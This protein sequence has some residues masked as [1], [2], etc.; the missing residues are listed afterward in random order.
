[1]M[2]K[3][4]IKVDHSTVHHLAIK[5]PPILEKAL[6]RRKRPSGGEKLACRNERRRQRPD[7]LRAVLLADQI[8]IPY[9]FNF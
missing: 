1:M 2:A 7:S 6:R 3:R 8:T 4:G 5:V 9:H